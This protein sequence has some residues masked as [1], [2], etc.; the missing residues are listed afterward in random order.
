MAG[1]LIGER[2][3]SGS[4]SK[5]VNGNIR[6]QRVYAT[7]YQSAKAALIDPSLPQYGESHPT[8]GN[9]KVDNISCNPLPDGSLDVVVRY[10]NDGTFAVL[11]P[12]KQ[13][14]GGLVRWNWGRVTVQVKIPMYVKVPKSINNGQTGGTDLIYVWD[15]AERVYLE[16]RVALYATALVNKLSF[17]ATT[18]VVNASDMVHK[19]QNVKMVC[20][21]PDINP[22]SDK[23]DEISYAWIADNGTRDPRLSSFAIAS[24]YYSQANPNGIIALPPNV[25]GKIRPPFTEVQAIP[26]LIQSDIHTGQIISGAPSWVNIPYANDDY[27][28]WRTLPGLIV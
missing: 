19:I 28:G 10:S 13:E 27:D 2:L 8:F 6:I 15:D 26:G 16:K 24:D 1:S 12:P 20:Q 22:H 11:A 14:V 18:Q 17:T 9:A 5:D 7:M 23:L 21:P 3:D 25:G 4:V